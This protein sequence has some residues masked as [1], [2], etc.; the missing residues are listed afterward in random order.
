MAYANFPAASSGGGIKSIQRGTAASAGT[1][2][3]TSVDTSKTFVNC[4]STASSGNVKASGTVSAW[5]GSTGSSTIGGRA[6]FNGA[7][8]DYAF[9]TLGN[10]GA[11]NVSGNAMNISGGTTNLMAGVNGAYLTGATSLVATGPCRYEIVEFA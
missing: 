3:I 8:G 11:F 2:T 1:I 4:F 5:N 9:S 6:E 7:I 10:V